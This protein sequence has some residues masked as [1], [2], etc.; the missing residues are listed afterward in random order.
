[1]LKYV[2]FPAVY[3]KNWRKN[4]LR[5]P[6]SEEHCRGRSDMLY[7]FEWLRKEKKVDRILKVIVDDSKSPPH[8]DEAIEL[9]LKGFGVEHLDWSKPDLDPDTIC[10]ASTEIVE[11]VLHWGGNNAVLRAWSD[12]EGLRRRLPNLSQVTLLTIC[13]SLLPVSS[14]FHRLMKTK[15]LESQERTEQSILNFRNR[16]QTEYEL[17]IPRKSEVEKAPTTTPAPAVDR[18]REAMPP[19]PVPNSSARRTTTGIAVIQAPAQ[20]QATAAPEPDPDPPAKLGAISVKAELGGLSLRPKNGAANGG[21]NGDA[22]SVPTSHR[23]LDSTDE[24]AQRID[25]VWRKIVAERT[26]EANA[27][28][29]ALSA[30]ATL[31]ERAE[32][33]REKGPVSDII[34]AVIDDGVDT[35]VDELIGRV[36]TGRTFDYEEDGDRV[37]PWY[38]SENNHGTIMAS[39]VV[40]VCRMA[41]IYPIRLRTVGGGIDPMSAAQAIDAAVDRGADIISMSWT[42]SPPQAK[43][44][45]KTAFDKALQRAIDNNVLMF[46]SAKDQGHA[47]DSHYPRDYRP[48]AVIKVGAANPTGLPYE[49]VGS[50]ERLDFIFPGVEVVQQHSNKPAGVAKLKGETGSSVATALGAGLAA[51]IMYCARIAHMYGRVGLTEADVDRLRRRDVMVEAITRFGRSS[52]E[53]TDGKFIEVWNRLDG[54]TRELQKASDPRVSRELIASLA[55]DLISASS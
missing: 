1:V 17:Y 15:T 44:E 23:W 7:F 21:P 32:I 18:D 36:L 34:V 55:R 39:M 19:P 22:A 47:G 20:P 6:P 10:N 45:L 49:W 2:A 31:T 30:N 5:V 51:V 28:L 52:S 8:S 48:E 27:A 42:V 25:N 14:L 53:K 12:P 4:P 11:L 41:K 24:F 35:T 29:S 54:R 9:C 37:R 43:S 13:V 40:R 50:L 38:V 16:M 3:V 33:M 46:C 26:K